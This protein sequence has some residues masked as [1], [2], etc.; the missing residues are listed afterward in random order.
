MR[1]DPIKRQA[2]DALAWRPP[3]GLQ[4]ELLE[5]DVRWIGAEWD[6]TEVCSSFWRL[7]VNNRDGAWLELSDGHVYELTGGQVYLVPAWVRFHCRHRDRRVEHFYVHFDV[8]GLPGAIVRQAFARPMD[9]GAVAAFEPMVGMLRT[10]PWELGTDGFVVGS[11]MQALLHLAISVAWGR[12]S[13]K[14]AAACR[15]FVQGEHRFGTVLSR[16]EEGLDEPL[17]NA[18]LARLC[19]LSR[20][21]FARRFHEQI[22]QPVRAYIRERRVA[23]AAELLRFTD[24][25]IDAIA[26]A[27]GFAD[28]FYF[29]R[30]FRQVMGTPPAGYRK[31]KRV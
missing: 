11:L 19:H 9:L 28:R 27:T 30:V 29:S 22:G 17:D 24:Q 8:R 13:G 26:Q 10:R 18:E 31:A 7:Y 14:Q 6:T 21:H 15:A 5:A 23:R 20:D 12:L 16:I 4:F 1:F 3:R 2:A 25:T